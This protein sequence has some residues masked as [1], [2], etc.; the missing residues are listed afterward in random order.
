[1]CHRADRQ[2]EGLPYGS[3]PLCINALI[4]GV[5]VHGNP[6]NVNENAMIVRL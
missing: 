2:G 4:G 6:V 3:S 5:S 1:M